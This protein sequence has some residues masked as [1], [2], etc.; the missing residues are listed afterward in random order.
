MSR[1]NLE[2]RLR[3]AAALQLDEQRQRQVKAIIHQ[4]DDAEKARER[5][6]KK[7]AAERE[8]KAQRAARRAK[9]GDKGQWT[10]V[11][12]AGGDGEPTRHQLVTESGHQLVVERHGTGWR[13]LIDGER[14]WVDNTLAMGDPN[15]VKMA[16]V[17]EYAKQLAAKAA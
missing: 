4:Q 12:R 10:A 6:A 15:F 1:P 3:Y 13:A 7:A 5:K 16:L 17:R 8:K 14:I 9:D 2:A 11:E